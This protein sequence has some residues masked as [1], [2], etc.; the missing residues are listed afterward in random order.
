MAA[1]SPIA[2]SIPSRRRGGGWLRR[3]ATSLLF[4]LLL[5]AVMLWFRLDVVN[6]WGPGFLS[7]AVQVPVG[8]SVSGLDWRQSVIE[9]LDLG[10]DGAVTMEGIRVSYDPL[11]LQVEE[12][13]IDRIRVSADIGATFSL[14]DLDPAIADLTSSGGGDAAGPLP[15]LPRIIVKAIELDLRSPVGIITGSGQATLDNQAIIAS[16]TLHE[17]TGG[18]SIDSDLALSLDPDAAAPNGSFNARIDATS[19]LWAFAGLVPPESGALTATARI[20]TDPDWQQAGWVEADWRLAATDF[21]QALLPEALT[22]TVSARSRIDRTGL[23]ILDLVADL[24]GGLAP[25][26]KTELA[27]ALTMRDAGAGPTLTG[28]FSLASKGAALD[29]AAL[30]AGNITLSEPAVALKADLAGKAIGQDGFDLAI[31]LREP[32]QIKASQVEVAGQLR[33]P[34]PTTLT[35]LPAETPLLTL[36]RD[37][38]GRLVSTVTAALDKGSLTLEPAALGERLILAMPKSALTLQHDSQAPAEVPALNAR[39]NL[40]GAQ[41]VLPGYGVTLADVALE[42]GYNGAKSLAT[43]SSAA[44]TGL[45]AFVP[46]RAEG[47]VTLAGDKAAFSA[48]FRGVDQPIDLTLN[49]KANIARA[50]GEIELDL[51]PIDFALGGLQPYNLFP[52]L[53]SYAEDVSGRVELAGPIR[54]DGGKL[55]SALKLGVE[56][57]SGKVGPVQVVNVNSVIEIDRPWP[58]S[59]KPDQAIAIQRADIGLPLTDAL[60]RF[61]ISD[62]RRLDV[63]ESR[64]QMSG[65]EVHLDPVSLD[66]EAP[67]HNVRL[68]VTKVSVSELFANLGIAGLSGEGSI[69]GILPVSIFPGGIAI[70]AAELKADAPGVL[71]YNREQAPLALQSAGDS[72]AMALQALSDFHY[73]ELIVTLTRELTGDVNLGLHISGSNPSFYDGYPV[74]F[75]L[76]V[77]GRLDE[78]LRQGLA[79]YQVPDMIQEQL[80]NLA[81]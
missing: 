18:A 62:G 22:G 30:G 38:T 4:L 9:R 70:P 69:S 20:R 1:D 13:E 57:F 8:F 77:E 34:Q 80:E 49:G 66:I 64:L 2:P 29:L 43:F 5:G 67:V 40:K 48:R 79:G 41:I 27:G 78:A 46:M 72:V 51:A 32:A 73:K 74:E 12:I 47:D 24:T 25:D 26:W 71:R 19:A 81:P 14:G 54:F 36:A 11:A 23:D 7:D 65:G 76:T 59:T 37:G 68:T 16:F 3:I 17:S 31:S 10:Q 35:L 45:G 15:R 75:N 39:F 61:K 58:L 21:R 28:S 42:A 63:A 55:T 53:R 6:R 50:S 60:F 52:P 33:L 56:N 44:V